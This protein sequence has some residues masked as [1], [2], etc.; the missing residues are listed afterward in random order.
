MNSKAVGF[1]NQHTAELCFASFFS[2]G[3]ITGIGVNPPERKLEN[4]PMQRFEILKN[5]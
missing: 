2:C 1:S 3:F 5:F 4:A